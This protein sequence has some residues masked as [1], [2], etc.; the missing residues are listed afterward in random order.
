MEVKCVYL[1]VLCTPPPTVQHL[2]LWRRMRGL[3][4]SSI[5]P[6]QNLLS[7]TF[8]TCFLFSKILPLE[9]HLSRLA[10]YLGGYFEQGHSEGTAAAQVSLLPTLAGAW[11]TLPTETP[12]LSAF[13]SF[14]SSLNLAFFSRPTPTNGRAVLPD[15]PPPPCSPF[16]LPP[17][18]LPFSYPVLVFP[19]S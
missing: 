19:F 9:A 16:P 18:S 13:C 4:H 10:L 17:G 14:R 1:C 7:F 6:R 3:L 12:R 8:L 5:P 11:D 15:S 2:L